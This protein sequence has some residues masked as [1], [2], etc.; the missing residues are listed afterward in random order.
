MGKLME[1]V[2]TMRLRSLFSP[3][4]AEQQFGCRSGHST[5]QALMRFVHAGALAA[6]AQESFG[7]IAFDFTKAYDRVPR[8]KMIQKLDHRIN[9]L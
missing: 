1:K 5:Q 8:Y 3:V 9:S 2:G 6:A 4:F 7:A